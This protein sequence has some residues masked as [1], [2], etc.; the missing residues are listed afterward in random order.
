MVRLLEH[1]RQAS[2]SDACRK[3]TREKSQ[4]GGVIARTGLRCQKR[5]PL[6]IP[7][8]GASRIKADGTERSRLMAIGG[9]AFSDGAEQDPVCL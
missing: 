4:L 9:K 8:D 7:I 6:E 2:R 5:A 1:L 3:E